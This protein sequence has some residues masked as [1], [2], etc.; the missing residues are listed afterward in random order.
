MSGGQDVVH[1]KYI[2]QSR[3]QRG[4]QTSARG[5]GQPRTAS[6]ATRSRRLPEG[7][8]DSGDLDED[9]DIFN[10]T[11]GPS[12]TDT[13]QAKVQ[14]IED[15]IAEENL[16]KVLGVKR[17]VKND[18]IRRAFL[19]R[20]RSCHPDKFPDYPNSTIAFQKL[21][22]AYETLSKP[23]SRQAYDFSP[24]THSMFNEKSPHDA[25]DDEFGEA[26]C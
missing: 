18:E 25:F 15:I 24:H 21:A 9:A 19:T 10:S 26:F 2:L 20:S 5:Q 13:F 17:N 23:A 16:Y 1:F 22:F 3:C 11:A 14:V 7:S 12:E 8:K 4:I 6:R